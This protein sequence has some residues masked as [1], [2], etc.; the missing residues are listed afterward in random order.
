M[1]NTLELVDK[2]RL[3]GAIGAL[4]KLPP[5]IRKLTLRFDRDEPVVLEIESLA[6]G[7]D[8]PVVES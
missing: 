8:S 6:T 5:H 7:L 1:K 4:V 3:L 2:E